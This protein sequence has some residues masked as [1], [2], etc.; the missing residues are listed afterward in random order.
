MVGMIIKSKKRDGHI[1][2]IWKFFARLRNYNICSNLSKCVFGVSSGKLLG[3]VVN[4]RGTEVN[5]SNI[6]AI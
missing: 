5:P 6:T 4:L 3:H 1:L 2:T